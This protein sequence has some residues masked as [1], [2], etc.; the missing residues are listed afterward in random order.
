MRIFDNCLE[1]TMNMQLSRSKKI[2]RIIFVLSIV[3]LVLGLIYFLLEV[4]GLWEKLNSVDKLQTVILELGFW[5]RFMFVFLQFLQVTFIPL[6][7]PVLIIVGSL[8][9]G[10]FEAGLLSLSGILFGSA[11]AFFIGRYFGRKIVAFMVGDKTADKWEKFLSGCKYTFVLMMLLPLFPDDVL[12][13]VAGLTDMNWTF[14]MVTQFI[15][16]PIGIFLVSYFSSGD[17][18]PYHGWGLVVWGVILILSIACI[19]LSSKYSSQIENF[20]KNIFSKRKKKGN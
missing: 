19:Y 9:Y 4:T 14:F 5:G 7:S 3:L 8:I 16:R 11:F 12:C 18:I 20:I 1:N 10:P 6:P 13:L 17:I 2:L 15:T